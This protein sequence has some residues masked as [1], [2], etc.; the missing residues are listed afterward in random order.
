[1]ANPVEVLPLLLVAVLMLS[2]GGADVD[3]LAVTVD[4]DH[5]VTDP[6]GVLIVGGGNVTV[7]PEASVDGPLYVAGGTVTLDGTVE[8][9]VVQLAGTL[10]VADGGTITDELRLFGGTRTLAAGADVGRV[11]DFPGSVTTERSPVDRAVSLL[12][13]ALVLGVL[14]YL[15]GRRFPRLLENVADSITDHGLVSGTIGLLASVTGIALLVFMALTILLLPVS[16]LGI[17]VGFLVV[18][19]AYVAFG[20]LLGRRLPIASTAR[21]TALGS[22]GFA[23]VVNLLALVPLLGVLVQGL[24]VLTGTGA[25]LI[26]YFGLREFEPVTLPA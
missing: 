26:T 15:L 17:G 13:Q 11:T 5:T 3:G 10:S 6:D 8:G 23:V 1:M 21:A 20:Y 22:A 19:Y 2:A 9:D 25:V 14:G 16:V 7:P 4:G 24:L 12:L 18:V